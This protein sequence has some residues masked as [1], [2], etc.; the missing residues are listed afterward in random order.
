MD[1]NQEPT[2]SHLEHP[3][4][5]QL[6][7][8]DEKMIEQEKQ[9]TIL[10]VFD[11]MEV[12]CKKDS[13][14]V[15]LK[16]RDNDRNLDYALKLFP[17][18]MIDEYSKEAYFNRGLSLNPKILRGVRAGWKHADSETVEIEGVTYSSF[19]YLLSPFCHNGTLMDLVLKAQTKKQKLSPTLVKYFAR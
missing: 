2:S 15:I 13:G 11:I 16:V 8:E 6:S 1:Y 18:S 10:G 5:D 19:G 17:D 14:V 4:V 7:T 12:V 3:S 9:A